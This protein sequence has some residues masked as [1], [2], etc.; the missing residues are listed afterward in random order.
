ML[1]LC[2]EVDLAEP[3]FMVALLQLYMKNAVLHGELT[4]EKWVD[5]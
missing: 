3:A 5:K 2:G 1:A 4:H